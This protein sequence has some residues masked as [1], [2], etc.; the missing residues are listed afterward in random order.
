MKT[1]LAA[2]TLLAAS[3]GL[4]PLALAQTTVATYQGRVQDNG[5]NFNGPGQFKF[6][7]VTS[8][9]FNHQATATANFSGGYVTIYTVTF[10]GNGYTVVPAV[11]V[12]GGGGSGASATAHLTGGA[13]TS[14]TVN[15]PG[16][17]SYTTAP[18]V[19]IAPPP[20]NIAYTTY[21]SNDG[22]SSAGSE[23]AA[24]VGVAVA[25][26]LFT[27]GLGDT[28]LAN[29]SAISALLFSQPNLQLRIWFS[30]GVSDFA[31]LS[32]LQSLTATP[33]ASF[34]NNASSAGSADSV[35]AANVTGTLGLAQL[36]GSVVTNGASG[37][38]ITGSFTGNGAGLTN[39]PLS[40]LRAVPLTN[41][42]SGVTFRGLT[43]VS[44]LSVTA[45]NFV[46]YLVVTNPPALNG[47]AI[48]SL[49]ASQLTSG[50]VPLGQLPGAVVTN[51]ETG[52]TLAGTF[53]GNGAALTNIPT[54]ALVAAPP[55][56][57][58]IPAGAFT[59]GNSIGDPDITDATPISTTVSAF[60]MD[61]NLVTWSQWQSVYRAL[62]KYLHTAC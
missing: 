46:N 11:T 44:N 32:P 7:L 47:S 20:A 55:G 56:M 49:N 58:L 28:A 26:G 38:N 61:V 35:A 2:L 21:W 62:H 39:L 42:Q 54:T 17:G 33:Y 45:T 16:N 40:A 6:A 15:H 53:S 5:T 8:T 9:N 50:T 10:G 37:V 30:D 12:S 34:A 25:S 51:N 27:V 3:L 57:V 52:V 60:Y 41:N 14:I 13:V 29:M 48:T 31:A 36:P 1:K 22:T 59:M 18:T 43:T 24:A 19:S 4:A 23:P